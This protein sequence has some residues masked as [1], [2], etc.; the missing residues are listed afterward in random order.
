MMCVGVSVA[1]SEKRNNLNTIQYFITEE[2]HYKRSTHKH[3]STFYVSETT[4]LRIK[5]MDKNRLVLR[6]SHSEH[7]YIE[8]PSFFGSFRR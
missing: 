3:F 4:L 5:I 6:V 7:K 2:T 8:A 1:V